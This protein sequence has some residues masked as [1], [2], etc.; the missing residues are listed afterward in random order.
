MQPHSITNLCAYC[1][2][3][4]TFKYPDRPTL[5][6]SRLCSL[7]SRTKEVVPLN[8]AY[9]GTSF[10]PAGRRANPERAFCSTV[11]ARKSRTKDPI[12]RFWKYVQKESHGCWI[13][14]GGC[15]SDGYGSFSAIP[16]KQTMLAHRFSYQ[17]HYGTLPDLEICHSCDNPPCV[18]PNHLF[19]GTHTQNMR[20]AVAK[21]RLGNGLSLEIAREIRALHRVL[22]NATIAERFNISESLVWFIVANKIWKEDV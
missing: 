21:G 18:N 15:T 14:I 17:L 10:L 3:S 12:D 9:C 13:W 2:Q 19:P 1:G 4:Y 5:F 7:K 20:D 11:C 22:P 6:C 16:G 8:C